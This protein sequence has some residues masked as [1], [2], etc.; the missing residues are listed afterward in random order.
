[1]KLPFSP[2]AV[3]LKAA[4]VAILAILGIGLLTTSGAFLLYGIAEGLN[5]VLERPWLGYLVTGFVFILAILAFL[6]I[7]IRSAKR[8]A[9]NP[10]PLFDPRAWV[11]MYPLPSAGVAMAAGFVTAAAAPSGPKG[12]EGKEP[13]ETPFWDPLISA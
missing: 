10:S 12:E 1:M 11:H 13:G 3:G 2:K 5:E 6:L 8:T 9:A 7:Q 4:G